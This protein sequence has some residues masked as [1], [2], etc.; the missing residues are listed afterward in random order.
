MEVDLNTLC[1][2]G[3]ASRDVYTVYKMLY[4]KPKPLLQYCHQL[5]RH[6]QLIYFSPNTNTTKP[7]YFFLFDT[8][9][10]LTK[11]TGSK[12]YWLKIYIHLRN[13]VQLIDAGPNDTQF[14]M[15][16]TVKGRGRPIIVYGKDLAHKALWIKDIRHVL[17]AVQGKKGP[18]PSLESGTSSTSSSSSTKA[19]T[20]ASSPRQEKRKKLTEKEKDEERRKR[21]EREEQERNKRRQAARTK[22][23]GDDD[24]DNSD[25]SEDED[26]I[27]GQGGADGDEESDEEDL[28][29]DQDSKEV[30]GLSNKLDSLLFDPFASIPATTAPSGLPG[31]STTTTTTYT[32][33]SYYPAYATTPGAGVGYVAAGAPYTAAAYPSVPTQSP[34]PAAAAGL[35]TAPGARTST[36]PVAGLHNIGGAPTQMPQRVMDVS[37]ISGDDFNKIAARGFAASSGTVPSS[38]LAAKP[39]PAIT[40]STYSATTQPSAPPAAAAGLVPSS[41][42]TTNPYLAYPAAT[43]AGA[44]PAGSTY[45]VGAGYPAAVAGLPMTAQQQQLQQQQQL[46]YQQQLQLLQQQQ[47]RLQQLQLQQQQLQ[48]QASTGGGVPGMTAIGVSGY[49]AVSTG[50]VAMP[51][52][53]GYGATTATTT[54]PEDPFFALLQRK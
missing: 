29:N 16:V 32:A 9:L 42:M 4:P 19:L 46:Y 50:A 21:I 17:W 18:D 41:T 48:Y 24:D 30:D 2:H 11:R 22:G 10:L 33:T 43:A 8:A 28:V 38:T 7:R 3:M 1:Q 53:V 31:T 49:P 34:A 39:A 36:V 47:Q 6:G 52:G 54:T 37:Q 51:G 5:I 20:S 27:R 45:A 23:R 12:K 26:D 14:R 44:V 13:G 35:M 40:S 15:M 25:F